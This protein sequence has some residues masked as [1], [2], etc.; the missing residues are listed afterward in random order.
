MKIKLSKDEVLLK[1][2]DMLGK[3]FPGEVTRRI[4]YLTENVLKEIAVN[5]NEWTRL[6]LD[7]SDG[8]YWE[9]FYPEYNEH[10]VGPPSLRNIPEAE[11][12]E[13]YKL[14]A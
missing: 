8:R 14:T 11:V 10:D 5:H 9:L 13:K 7:E 1:G 4:D 2:E 3:P 6:Y 12:K